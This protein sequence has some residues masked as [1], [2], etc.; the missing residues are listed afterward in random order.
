MRSVREL[1]WRIALAATIGLSAACSSNPV[2]TG[3]PVQ[4]AAVDATN[5][6]SYSGSSPRV[7]VNNLNGKWLVT[8]YQGSSLSSQGIKIE[9]VTVGGTILR[10]RATFSEGPG[11]AAISPSQTIAITFGPD[12][13]LLFDQAGRERARW[14]S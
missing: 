3:S 13:V 1:A 7:E 4:Y 5:S 2:D 6:S 14:P 9:K 8:V 11:S 12:Q 10:V